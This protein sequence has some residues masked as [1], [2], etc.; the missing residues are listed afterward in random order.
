MEM[1]PAVVQV[2]AEAEAAVDASVAAFTAVLAG[3]GS[4][5]SGAVSVHG[6]AERGTGFCRRI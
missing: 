4:A 5:V 3:G 6:G 2:V 1:T